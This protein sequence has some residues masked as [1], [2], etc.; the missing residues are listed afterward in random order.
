[1]QFTSWV[2]GLYRITFRVLDFTGN[3][4]LYIIYILI[5]QKQDRSEAMFLVSWRERGSLARLQGSEITIKK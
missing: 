2:T 3:I 5:A 4:I 1:M